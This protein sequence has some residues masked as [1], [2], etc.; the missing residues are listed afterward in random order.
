MSIRLGCIFSALAVFAG[1]S[2]GWGHAAGRGGGPSRAIPAPQAPSLPPESP[3]RDL[4]RSRSAAP[5]IAAQALWALAARVGARHGLPRG[6][7]AAVIQAE[8][9]GRWALGFNRNGSCDVGPAQVNVPG[10]DLLRVAQLLDLETNLAAG[11]RILKASS[12]ACGQRPW[13]RG[14]A[15]CPWGRYNPWSTT[16]CVRVFNTV[17]NRRRRD[18]LGSNPPNP[19]A[20]VPLAAR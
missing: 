6:L 12:R 18:A 11:A 17:V 20:S 4:G 9:R 13:L 7:L 15:V 5:Q 8:S 19:A 1:I 10:C 3:R 2:M 16:W 14:C